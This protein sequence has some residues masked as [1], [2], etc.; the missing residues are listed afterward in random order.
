MGSA[1]ADEE[2]Y[3]TASRQLMIFGNI[4]SYPPSRFL[5][6]IP[7][8]LMEAV[9]LARPVNST[10]SASGSRFTPRQTVKPHPPGTTEEWKVGDQ[11]SHSKWGTGTVVSAKGEGE[12]LELSVAF[13]GQGIKRLMAAYAPLKRP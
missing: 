13:S 6:E 10:Y 12:T 5:A 11:V 3:L 9:Q 7:V 8:N 4:V 2:L 1:P